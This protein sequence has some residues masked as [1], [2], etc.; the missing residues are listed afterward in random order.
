[1]FMLRRMC[2]MYFVD[3]IESYMS[4]SVCMMFCG[5]FLI[6]NALIPLGPGALVFLCMLSECCNSFISIGRVSGW[7]GV[8][9][10]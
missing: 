3:S 10:S 5:K 4:L 7:F 9:L 8:S 1:M 2:G 6:C